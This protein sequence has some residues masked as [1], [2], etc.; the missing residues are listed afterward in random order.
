MLKEGSYVEVD[1]EELDAELDDMLL[2]GNDCWLRS[3]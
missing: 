2:F 3:G 1:D